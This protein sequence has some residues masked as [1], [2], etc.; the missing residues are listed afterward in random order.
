MLRIRTILHP[1]DFSASA[2][3]AWQVACSLAR[4]Y[5]A[6]LIL[7]HVRTHPIPPMGEFGMLPPEA[8]NLDRAESQLEAIEPTTPSLKV[9]RFVV[10]GE[11]AAEIIDFAKKHDCD[12]IVMGT[13]GRKGLGRL[14]MGSIAEEVVRKSECAVLTMKQPMDEIETGFTTE[15]VEIAG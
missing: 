15:A 14:F 1:T 10:E 4:E 11:G 12:L 9:N 7:L 2:E 6:R 3:Y 5:G 13:H 8:E